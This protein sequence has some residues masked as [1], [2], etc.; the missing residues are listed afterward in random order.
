M[1]RAIVAP[2]QIGTKPAPLRLA[3]CGRPT[4]SASTQAGAA[5]KPSD[6]QRPG[7]GDAGALRPGR[8]SRPLQVAGDH[9]EDAAEVGADQLEGSNRGNRNQGGAAIRPYSI[10]V[11][12]FSS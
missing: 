5:V 2:P 7:K 10:A 6:R 9:V 11:A 12:P 8:R 1:A 4:R 3:N